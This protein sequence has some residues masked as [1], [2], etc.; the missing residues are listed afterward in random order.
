MSA[1]PVASLADVLLAR[2]AILPNERLLKRAEKIKTNHSTLPEPGSALWTFKNFSLD[3]RKDQ[4]LKGEDLT[5]IE[6]LF[7]NSRRF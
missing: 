6:Q 4:K 7:S 1:S 5:L 2:H 3:S